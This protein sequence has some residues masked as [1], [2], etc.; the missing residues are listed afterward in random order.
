M[1]SLPETHADTL[2]PKFNPTTRR[3][4]ERNPHAHAPPRECYSGTQHGTRNA[5]WMAFTG[6]DLEEEKRRRGADEKRRRGEEEK[7]PGAT[8]HHKEEKE[9]L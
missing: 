1:Q 4:F 9:E 5:Y 7:D 8:H 2:K 3:K 6:Q